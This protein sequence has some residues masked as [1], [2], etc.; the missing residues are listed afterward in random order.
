MIYWNKTDCIATGSDA[1]S[2]WQVDALEAAGVEVIPVAP[3]VRQDCFNLPSRPAASGPSAWAINVRKS[4]SLPAAAQ[5]GFRNRISSI[6][7]P[8]PAAEASNSRSRKRSSAVFDDDEE[9][10]ACQPK[11]KARKVQTRKGRAANP[12]ASSGDD[13]AQKAIAP[14]RAS[15]TP[16]LSS[17]AFATPPLAPVMPAGSPI[18]SVQPTTVP[19]DEDTQQWEQDG[20]SLFGSDDDSLFGGD[21]D[22]SAALSDDGEDKVPVVDFL[23]AVFEEDESKQSEDFLETPFE[24]EAEASTDWLADALREKETAEESNLVLTVPPQDDACDEPEDF[25]AAAFNEADDEER[26]STAI[27]GDEDLRVHDSRQRDQRRR[28]RFGVRFI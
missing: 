17:G 16:A 28:M 9:D 4:S 18:I 21:A 6:V 8:T 22:F 19:L 13:Q 1:F 11:R 5:S 20:D 12:I 2:Q 3:T 26:R 7:A 14:T 25:F 23:T 15:V 27:V 24:D 10:R